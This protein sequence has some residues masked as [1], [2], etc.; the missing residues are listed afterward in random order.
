MHRSL[1]I[2][3][4]SLAFWFLSGCGI[5]ASSIVESFD[6]DSY[7]IAGMP[8]SVFYSSEGRTIIAEELLNAPKLNLDT[9]LVSSYEETSKYADIFSKACLRNKLTKSA[10]SFLSLGMESIPLGRFRP[11]YQYYFDPVKQ[12]EL[13][14]NILPEYRPVA[15]SMIRKDGFIPGISGV[16][17]IREE[18][19]NATF[20]DG[21][22]IAEIQYGSE[23][24]NVCTLRIRAPDDSPLIEAFERVV[25]DSG[26]ELGKPGNIGI[27]GF[28]YLINTP[29]REAILLG[30]D[31]LNS[32]TTLT[33]ILLS[34]FL[35]VL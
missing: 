15:D 18:D 8:K 16:S 22:A 6:P 7:K 10:E 5:I 14:E 29:Q 26:R 2:I 32:P 19:N 31:S 33:Y 35:T 1:S 9:P 12:P 21:I 27:L 25:K 30:R 34:N 11:S 13:Y 28:G 20:T 3:C 24:N 17:V 23:I 4:M